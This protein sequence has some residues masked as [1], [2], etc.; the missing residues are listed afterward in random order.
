MLAELK[1][2]AFKALASLG[3]TLNAWKEKWQECGVL[4]NLT[5]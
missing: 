2:S 5:L 4:V 1:Q 3:K